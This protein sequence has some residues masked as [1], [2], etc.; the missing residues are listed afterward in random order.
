MR[1]PSV[2]WAG[3]ERAERVGPGLDSTGGADRGKTHGL[4]YPVVVVLLVGLVAVAGGQAVAGFQV[5][6]KSIQLGPPSQ[7]HTY[8]LNTGITEYSYNTVSVGYGGGNARWWAWKAKNRHDVHPDN[9]EAVSST[10]TYSGGGPYWIDLGQGVQLNV[11]GDFHADAD[12]WF[13]QE[14]DTDFT[15]I[16]GAPTV[17]FYVRGNGPVQSGDPCQ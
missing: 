3:V 17:L 10:Y 1:V 6:T 4:R 8:P 15:K 14:G 16:M 13:K 11:T 5:L 7:G 12:S 2:A 9:N